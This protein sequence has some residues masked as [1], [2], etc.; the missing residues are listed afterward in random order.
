MD[1]DVK[2]VQAELN[3]PCGYSNP[4]EEFN[5]DLISSQFYWFLAARNQLR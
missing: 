5:S 1:W 3:G 4:W 2:A